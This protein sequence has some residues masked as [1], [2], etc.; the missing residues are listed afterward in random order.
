MGLRGKLR[1]YTTGGASL[2][3]MRWKRLPLS[4]ILLS[5][6]VIIRL[7]CMHKDNYVEKPRLFPVSREEEGARDAGGR[8]LSRCGEC[9]VLLYPTNILH[10]TT[11]V[12]LL[13]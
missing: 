5:P 9:G 3:L 1:Q 7:L 8:D 10:R 11:I 2:H 12:R 4:A 6:G 13:V